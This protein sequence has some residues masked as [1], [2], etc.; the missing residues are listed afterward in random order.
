MTASSSSHIADLNLPNPAGIAR[1]RW[2]TTTWL[3]CVPAAICLV[4]AIRAI[5][6]ELARPHPLSPWESAIVMDAWRTTQ[7]IKVYQFPNDGPA[8]HMY[9]PL[10]TYLNALIFLA[11][12]PNWYTPRCVALASALLVTIGFVG[13]FARRGGYLCN[14]WRR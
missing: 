14:R 12:G 4:L 6:V 8:T 7:G 5:A 10:A 11:T 9:G 13:A 2:P 1:E 3:A